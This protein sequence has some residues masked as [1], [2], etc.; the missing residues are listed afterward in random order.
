MLIFQ[1][2]YASKPDLDVIEDVCVL[3]LF[4][5]LRQLNF[6]KKKYAI[7]HIRDKKG[8]LFANTATRVIL[9]VI[10]VLIFDFPSMDLI[11]SR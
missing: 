11:Y 4:Y 6:N 5:F 7:P 8:L 1:F 2:L 3:F 10:Q 9:T